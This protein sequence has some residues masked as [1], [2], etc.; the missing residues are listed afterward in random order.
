MRS[1]ASLRMNVFIVTTL[2]ALMSSSCWVCD[3]IP[4]TKYFYHANNIPSELYANYI[5]SIFGQSRPDGYTVGSDTEGESNY[6]AVYDF[7]YS[8]SSPAVSVLFGRKNRSVHVTFKRELISPPMTM[9]ASVTK[10]K[11]KN[12]PQ[13]NIVEQPNLLT[14]YECLKNA[15]CSGL[16]AKQLEDLRQILELSLTSCDLNLLVQIL[17]SSAA[18]KAMAAIDVIKPFLIHDA[19]PSLEALS[20]NEQRKLFTAILVATNGQCGSSQGQANPWKVEDIARAVFVQFLPLELTKKQRENAETAMLVLGKSNL[21]KLDIVNIFKHFIQGDYFSYDGVACQALYNFLNSLEICGAMTPSSLITVKRKCDSDYNRT[22]LSSL[23]TSTQGATK[24]R[25]VTVTSIKT[26]TRQSIT[27][28]NQGTSRT[29]PRKTKVPLPRGKP[30]SEA[31]PSIPKD[32][33]PKDY[34][35]K[36]YEPKDYEP[37]DYEPKDYEIPPP[38]QESS[39]AM[40]PSSKKKNRTLNK[41][42]RRKNDKSVVSYGRLEMKSKY[43]THPKS[44]DHET[45]NKVNVRKTEKSLRKKLRKTERKHRR[46]ERV[47]AKSSNGVTITSSPELTSRNGA[48]ASPTSART[49]KKTTYHENRYWGRGQGRKMIKGQRKTVKK[50]EKTIES[51]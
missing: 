12:Y 9:L 14:I 44:K 51:F 35:P 28:A 50:G 18:D 47:R 22:P 29:W 37:K 33:E 19:Q 20:E 13:E 3:A 46:K 6:R 11:L 34:E 43:R 41:G 49:V 23:T 42:Q 40:K 5:C 45:N 10:L 8:F 31:T 39:S 38:G 36:D 17:F 15:L 16:T 1:D 2:V 25:P 27:E 7:L 4:P 48:T 26:T 32:Y 21:R 24:T 30:R